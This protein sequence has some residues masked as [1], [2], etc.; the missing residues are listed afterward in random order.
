MTV[1]DR[2]NTFV[3]EELHQLINDDLDSGAVLK[4]SVEIR[5]GG[6][7]CDERSVYLPKGSG[8]QMRTPDRARVRPLVSPSVGI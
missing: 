6:G 7:R 1:T 4:T 5:P 8:G 2:I 3:I